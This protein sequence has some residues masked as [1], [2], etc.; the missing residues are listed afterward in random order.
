M[1]K[2]FLI[3]DGNSLKCDRV[4]I[5]LP[6]VGVPCGEEGQGCE[7]EFDAIKTMSQWSDVDGR[8]MP[9][10]NTFPRLERGYYSIGFSNQFGMYFIKNKVALNKLYRLP[11]LATDIVM[12]DISKFWTLEETYKKYQRVFRRNYLLYSAHCCHQIQK[13]HCLLCCCLHLH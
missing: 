5:D 13:S 6:D 12:N 4:E 9:V 7:E 10:S 8:I 2:E 11:N 3:D 1:E